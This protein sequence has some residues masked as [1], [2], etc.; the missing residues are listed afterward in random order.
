M[1]CSGE[2]GGYL[3]LDGCGVCG[4]NCTTFCDC[5]GV[6]DGSTV[7]DECG[8]CGG[9][10]I[11]D[12]ECDCY[13]NVEDCAGVCDG[14]TTYDCTGV[15]GGDA[16]YD[17]AGVC[18]G[19]AEDDECG[20]C[21]GPGEVYGSGCCQIELD[22]D[23]FCNGGLSDDCAGV[24]GGD[25]V[26]DCAGVCGGTSEWGDPGC[27]LP[28][29][30]WYEVCHS[31]CGWSVTWGN[32]PN[33]CN[34][35]PGWPVSYSTYPGGPQ[36]SEVYDC[37]WNDDPNDGYPHCPYG[38][39]DSPGGP[40]YD[41]HGDQTPF[42]FEH[43]CNQDELNEGNCNEFCESKGLNCQDNCQWGEYIAWYYMLGIEDHT[44]GGWKYYGG[45]S[46]DGCNPD[47]SYWYQATNS[48]DL[49]QFGVQYPMGC[50]TD[51]DDWGDDSCYGPYDCGI[52]CCCG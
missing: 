16:V 52:R 39:A 36:N 38:S 6:C 5:A 27:E 44:G 46:Q 14:D 24:C 1:D 50:N 26:Y 19:D 37:D 31:D 15:C 41:H 8:E 42:T 13:G 47:M 18:G 20:V 48:E 17:C 51:F 9:S 12:G 7:V 4:G 10:G 25:A 3:E 49:C 40:L 2:C 21:N 11:P 34:E 33:N 29:N 35:H 22:C 45:N 30:N 43:D 32:H 28:G 23:G